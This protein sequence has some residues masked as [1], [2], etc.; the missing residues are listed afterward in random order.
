MNNTTGIIKLY[1]DEELIEQLTYNY[2]Y[3]RHDIVARWLKGIGEMICESYI[4]IEPD[5]EFEEDTMETV[6]TFEEEKEVKILEAGIQSKYVTP[7]YKMAQVKIFTGY[8]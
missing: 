8:K 3:Q 2:L 7:K 1:I 4:Q 6:E 5:I